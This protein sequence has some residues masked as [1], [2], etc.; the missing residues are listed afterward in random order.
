MKTFRSNCYRYLLLVTI[1][2][3]FMTSMAG[4]GPSFREMHKLKL[5]F[6]PTVNYYEHTDDFRF[7]LCSTKTDMLMFDGTSGKILWKINFKSEFANEKFSNQFW[8]RNANVILVFDEDT[9]KGIADKYFIDGKTGKLLWKN[10]KYVSDYGKYELSVGF[11]NYF[12]AETNGVLLPTKDNVDF[13]DVYSGNVIWSKS[14]E[15]TGKAKQFD[16]YIMNYYDLVKINLSKEEGIYLTTRDGKEVT[17]IEP[18]FNK[19]KYMADRK[20]A[21]MISIPEKNMYIVMQGETSRMMEI[22]GIIGGQSVDIP[23]WKM[24]FIAYEEGSN[25][26][27][28]RQKYTIGF[29]YDWI[30][31]TPLVRLDYADGKLFVQHDAALKTNDGLTVIDVNTGEKLWTAYYSCSE[32]KNGLSK[33]TLTPFPAPSPVIVDGN[34]YVVDKVKNTVRCYNAQNGTL[35]WESEKYPDA[36]KIPTLIVNNGTV[37]LVHGSPASK[38]VRAEERSGNSSRVVYK[39]MFLDK[40]KYGL[41]AYDAKTGKTIWDGDQAGKKAKDKF[42]YIAGAEYVDGKLYCATDKNFFILDPP[43]GNVIKSI[44][45]SKE[46]LGDAWKLVYFP[47]RKIM[48]LNCQKGIIKV[49]PLTATIQGTVKTPNVSSYPASLHMNADNDYEDYAIFTSGNS[50]KL[51]FKTFASIDLDKMQVRGTAPAALLF[52][53]NPHFSDGADLFYSADG[54]EVSIFSIK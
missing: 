18:Y 50:E 49:D 53:D 51:D 44:P 48:V 15:L 11:Q 43:T 3:C 30:D 39:R 5:P 25:K 20:H 40:D 8:N 4:S 41:I 26:E 36:Q 6:K 24:N 1:L 7:F 13:V 33:T 52:Y 32:M 37:I 2:G 12:D 54:N 22:L 14:F 16:C 29:V 38:I 42:S 31:Y 17:E 28:W 27:L 19:K 9:K 34:A 10:N 47:D 45:V 23:K 46:K 35:I 21:T